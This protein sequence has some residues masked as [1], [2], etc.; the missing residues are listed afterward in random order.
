[1]F[2]VVLWHLIINKIKLNAMKVHKTFRFNEELIKVLE[3]QAATENRNLSNLI[4]TILL[5][6]VNNKSK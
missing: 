1:M 4:E 6:Y 2:C 3:L 5:D